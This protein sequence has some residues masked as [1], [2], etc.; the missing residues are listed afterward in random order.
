MDR[1]CQK[2]AVVVARDRITDVGAVGASDLPVL[3]IRLAWLAGPRRYRREVVD[4]PRHVK[5]PPGGNTL[6]PGRE[7]PSFACAGAV[8][9]WKGLPHR[10]CPVMSLAS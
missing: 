2:L 7:D 4:D 6:F 5:D 1:R 9:M 3:F 8:M 10:K